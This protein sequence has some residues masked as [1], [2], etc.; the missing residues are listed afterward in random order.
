MTTLNHQAR[1]FKTAHE[2]EVL[3]LPNAWDAASA[4]LAENAGAAAIATT[5]GGVAWSLGGGDGQLMARQDMVKAAQRIIHAV[6]V[7]VT[8]DIEG[9]YGPDPEEVA[10]TVREVIAAGAAGINLEDSVPTGGRLFNVADQVRRLRAARE[11][12]V[13][14]N[15]PDLV[16]NA[17]C[18][19][20][21]DGAESASERLGWARERAEAYVGAGAD[22]FFTPGLVDLKVIH[23]LASSIEMP[24]NVMALPGGPTVQ[25]FASAGAR[26]VSIGTGLAQVAF[27]AARDAMARFLD[28]GEFEQD[29]SLIPLAD[30]QGLFV[31]QRA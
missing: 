5:S 29:E 6:D 23:A 24:V 22:F 4:A 26:R 7:P 2:T 20:F 1:R 28:H 11:A 25:E 9:G 18:D 17:R 13:S 16:I 27:G 12:A 10:T 8:V 30:L 19:V 15:V 14:E 21:L 3:V 31:L